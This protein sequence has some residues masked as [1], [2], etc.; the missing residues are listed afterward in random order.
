MG[1]YSSK[2]KSW[3]L[4]RPVRSVEVSDQLMSCASDNLVMAYR[5]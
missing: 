4:R 2:I 1:F 5:I 3:W